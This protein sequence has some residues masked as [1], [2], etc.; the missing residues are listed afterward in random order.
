MLMV[1]VFSLGGSTVVIL[2]GLFQASPLFP[3]CRL[4]FIVFGLAL[5]RQLLHVFR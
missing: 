5:E 4:V 1:A 3:P 2:M